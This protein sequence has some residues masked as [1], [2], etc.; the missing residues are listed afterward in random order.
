MI[1]FFIFATN[2]DN[3]YYCRAAYKKLSEYIAY[4]F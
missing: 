3:M 2:D 1:K 4:P